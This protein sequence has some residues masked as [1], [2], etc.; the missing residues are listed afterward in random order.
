[1]QH[2]TGNS[3]PKS[4]KRSERYTQKELRFLL[5]EVQKYPNI[6][7]S[8]NSHSETKHRKFVL[9]QHISKKLQNK[10][11]D[12]SLKSPVQLRNWW[13]RTKSRAKQ[14][15][16]CGPCTMEKCKFAENGI[17]EVHENSRG[18]FKTIFSEVC[19][20]RRQIMTSYTPEKEDSE[21]TKFLE[22]TSED[23]SSEDGER[24]CG[25]SESS[26]LDNDSSIEPFGAFA[27]E[28][29]LSFVCNSSIDL[30]ENGQVRNS[31][32]RDVQKVNNISP[33][34]MFGY[35]PT[36]TIFNEGESILQ[37]DNTSSLLSQ[38]FT[39]AAANFLSNYK[40]LIENP[41]LCNMNGIYHSDTDGSYKNLDENSGEVLTEELNS[42]GTS[43]SYFTDASK[44]LELP[45]NE[46]NMFYIP[47][48]SNRSNCLP[49]LN[50][51]K[52][53][54]K[55]INGSDC[56]FLWL[57]LMQIDNEILKLKKRKLD[58]EITISDDCLNNYLQKLHVP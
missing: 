28:N 11:P 36:V 20:F 30:Q 42:N 9:W 10:F 8:P 7:E 43:S 41:S 53:F 50:A 52:S 17:G 49:L 51:S 5:E 26:E 24:A 40:H 35:D 27:H 48:V 39:N 54:R 47:S 16:S 14:R 37:K 55:I 58:L 32:P 12:S 4:G 13:K 56:S 44:N 31:S 21:F 33:Q 38:I 18:Y 3:L 23:H 19:E 57:E 2:S 46:D 1:M 6:I 29:A 34:N 15:L 25:P 45:T 22:E